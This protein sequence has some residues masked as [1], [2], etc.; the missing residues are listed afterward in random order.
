MRLVRL[1]VEG[2]RG[3]PSR[4]SFDLDADA[5]VVVGTNGAGKTSLLDAVLWGL[6]GRLDRVE[7]AGGTVRSG[8]SASGET[9]VALELRGG[10]GSLRV[11]RS[12]LPGDKDPRL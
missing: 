12:Q 11:V 1:E 10:D 8:F 9:R 2:F 4:E 7:S 5:V 6:T 3:L